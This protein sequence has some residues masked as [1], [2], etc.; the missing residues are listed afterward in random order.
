LECIR[1][2]RQVG[3]EKITLWTNEELIAARQ[4]YENEGFQV[5][6]K[7]PHAMFGRS[8]VGETWE[9]KLA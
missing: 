8:M 6:S 2:A 1:F 4:I 9:L 3:Y 7:E 5:V